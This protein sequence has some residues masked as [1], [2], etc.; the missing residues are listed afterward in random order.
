[1]GGNSLSAET[2]SPLQ[3]VV[4]P[5]GPGVVNGKMGTI[6]TDDVSSEVEKSWE[7]VHLG[8]LG[9]TAR[10]L[11]GGTQGGMYTVAA[12][13]GQT[14]HPAVPM[15]VSRVQTVVSIP[16]VLAV[17]VPVEVASVPL[18]PPSVHNAH[19][20]LTT[21]SMQPPLP[22]RPSAFGHPK[23]T[24]GT[25]TL[26]LNTAKQMPIVHR[27]ATAVTAHNGIVQLDGVSLEAGDLVIATHGGLPHFRV[28]G[29]NHHLLLLSIEHMT[30][31][32]KGK[33][34]PVGQNGIKQVRAA[35]YNNRSL[36]A[37]I[38]IDTDGSVRLQPHIGAD[39]R[40]HLH[41]TPFGHLPGVAN[42][43]TNRSLLTANTGVAVT[44]DMTTS[45]VSS[46]ADGLPVTAGA[47]TPKPHQFTHPP[48]HAHPFKPVPHGVVHSHFTPHFV[49]TGN[50]K[51]APHVSVVSTFPAAT[52][53]PMA[54]PHGVTVQVASRPASKPV[55]NGHGKTSSTTTTTWQTTVTTPATKQQPDFDVRHLDNRNSGGTYK[56]PIDRERMTGRVNPFRPLVNPLASPSPEAIQGGG[57]SNPRGVGALPK[58]PAVP[59]GAPVPLGAPA[60]PG[61]HSLAYNLKA[62]MVGDGY[63]PTALVSVGGKTLAVGLN[64]TLP[65]NAKVKSI[66][67]DYVILSANGHDV[68]LNLKR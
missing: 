35:L 43:R 61:A 60:A 7:R 54:I 65:G 67:T 58:I 21:V 36:A 8:D 38:A 45:S 63:P 48:A 53:T 10:P 34:F 30:V 17:P 66:Q 32:A 57:Q 52:P 44:A 50:A 62:I 59:M 49:V 5:R 26:A 2:D 12:P 37:H 28:I 41:I 22:Q 51:P 40:V 18:A 24:L 47:N 64:Q 68:R 9:S 29:G 4:K 33:L 19:P 6:D 39:G 3:I 31:A 11:H 46:T 16:R 42:A 20:A 15:A 13:A 27:P 14:V 25:S 56:F 23:S 55:A 1:M